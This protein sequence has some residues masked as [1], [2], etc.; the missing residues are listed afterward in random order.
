[1]GSVVRIGRLATRARI[2]TAQHRDATS[3]WLP[4][5]ERARHAEGQIPERAGLDFWPTT[6]RHGARAAV[7]MFLAIVVLPIA[8]SIGKA[9]TLAI[10]LAIWG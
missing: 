1:M 4:L 5:D 3:A 10:Y 2:R 7:L 9:A 6:R 8:V